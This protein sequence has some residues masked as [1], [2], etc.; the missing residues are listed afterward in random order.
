MNSDMLMN[1][2]KVIQTVETEINYDERTES[3]VVLA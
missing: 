2:K 3:L 1:Q